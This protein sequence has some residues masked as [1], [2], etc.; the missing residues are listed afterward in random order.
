MSW[1]CWFTD[2]TL[3]ISKNSQRAIFVPICTIAAAA[4]TPSSRL[5]KR[6]TAADIFSG[7]PNILKVSS[8]II[9]S[10]PSEPTIK[11]VKS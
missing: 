10:V 7:I 4:F 1:L 3:A 5:S 6:T 11:R 8:V 2:L 9:P